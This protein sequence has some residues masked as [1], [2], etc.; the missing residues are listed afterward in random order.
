MPVEGELLGDSRLRQG[1]TYYPAVHV[2]EQVVAVGNVVKIQRLTVAGKPDISFGHLKGIWLWRDKPYIRVQYLAPVLA[3]PPEESIA[4]KG[5]PGSG[6]TEVLITSKVADLPLD[7]LVRSVPIFFSQGELTAQ[8]FQRNVPLSNGPHLQ[9]TRLVD[10]SLKVAALLDR[11]FQLLPVAQSFSS[12][13]MHA[14]CGLEY[15]EEE[16]NLLG[17]PRGVGL[18]GHHDQQSRQLDRSKPSAG[19]NAPKPTADERSKPAGAAV[20]PIEPIDDAAASRALVGRVL[21]RCSLDGSLLQGSKVVR[22]PGS[23]DALRSRVAQLYGLWGPSVKVSYTKADDER[24]QKVPLKHQADLLSLLESS[25]SLDAPPNAQ[26]LIVTGDSRLPCLSYVRAALSVAAALASLAFGL[27]CAWLARAPADGVPDD[28]MTLAWYPYL[29]YG[30]ALPT[31]LLLY[32]CGSA[33]VCMLPE[34]KRSPALRSHLDATSTG[35]ALLVLTGLLG[36]DVLLFACD[37][38]LSAVEATLSR[39][40]AQG[41][42]QLAVLQHILH[43]APLVAASYLLHSAGA[44]AAWEELS[45]GVLGVSVAA[46]VFGLPWLI[47]EFSQPR[48]MVPESLEAGVTYYSRRGSAS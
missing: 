48:N 1:L 2:K 38:R 33:L 18:P 8:V 41:L 39:G 45:F 29:M 17:L 34:Y 26:P 22:Y 27:L 25:R 43:G 42:R 36:P 13:V 35:A 15:E 46:L 16:N 7:V 9:C 24:M 20:A 21:L 37:A 5:T 23:V 31:W 19:A 30:V 10:S 40:T 6:A 12:E 14:V 28:M 3:N 4:F 32:N 11:G 47:V 44:G